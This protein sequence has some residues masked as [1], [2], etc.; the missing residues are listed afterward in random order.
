MF[1][2]VERQVF[3]QQRA[4]A[5]EAHVALQ[6]VPQFGQFVQAGGAQFASEG[7]EAFGIGQGAAVF[8]RRV[9][10]GTEF[11]H[12]EGDAAASGADLAEQDGR[13][14]FA[15]YLPGEQQQDGR[16]QDEC[17]GDDDDVEQ[18]FDGI[19]HGFRRPSIGLGRVEPSGWRGGYPG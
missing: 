2:V 5:D 13:A 19:G 14:E 8:V 4:G 1:G 6:Y 18:A 11:V 15:P 9:A 17:Y 7:C 3:H 10:H 16:Q 12:H